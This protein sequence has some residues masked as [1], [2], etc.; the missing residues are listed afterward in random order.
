MDSNIAS[1]FLAVLCTCLQ[2]RTVP[3][4]ASERADACMLDQARRI[5]VE[6]GH[7]LIDA[8]TAS[9]K[10]VHEGQPGWPLA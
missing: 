4:S 7:M 8:V 2:V 9:I 5:M 6:L 1:H 3:A 10:V